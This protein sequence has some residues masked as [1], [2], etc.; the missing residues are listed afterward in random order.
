MRF[1]SK[2]IDKIVVHH[3]ASPRNTTLEQIREWHVE[4]NGWDAIGY[5]FVIT[6]D[7]MIHMTRPTRFMGAHCRG[8]NDG[9]LGICLTGNNTVEEDQW[10]GAQIISLHSLVR[11]LRVVF[12][13][14]EVYGHRD[15]N[16]GTECPGRDVQPWF[17]GP[18]YERRT[19]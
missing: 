5:H 4:Q 19:R 17:S 18:I 12:N 11:S 10:D 14:P 16:E 9:S 2:D 1:H 3:S 13:Y 15:L 7:G 6:G 8:K